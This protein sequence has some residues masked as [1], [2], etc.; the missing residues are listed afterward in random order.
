MLETNLREVVAKITNLAKRLPE[1]VLSVEKEYAQLAAELSELKE[2]LESLDKSSDSETDLDDGFVPL[3]SDE[4]VKILAEDKRVGF[5]FTHSPIV[6]SADF[7]QKLV[8]FVGSYSSNEAI[9]D[10]VKGA[11]CQVSRNNINGWE[12][13]KV[14][15]RLEFRPGER[16][17]RT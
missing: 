12:V 14:R 5:A 13:G 11:D 15:L 3:A 4:V 8:D 2:R 10:W 6:E 1:R 17:D 7:I 16:S 9:R